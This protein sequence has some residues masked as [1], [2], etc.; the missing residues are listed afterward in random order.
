MH[1]MVLSKCLKRKEALNVLESNALTGK[2]MNPR[3][4]RVKFFGLQKSLA[5]MNAEEFSFIVTRNV[6]F[7]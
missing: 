5:A 3:R 4:P 2:E 1:H 7:V 6:A